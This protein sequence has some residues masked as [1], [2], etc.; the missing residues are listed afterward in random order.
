V[1]RETGGSAAVT[2]PTLTKTNYTEWAILMRIALQGAGLWEAMDTSDAT[3]RQ[4][5]QALGAILRSVSSDMVSALAAG[6]KGKVAWDMLKTMRIGDNR[7]REARH[8][9]L[10][11]E[12]NAMAFKSGES[13]ED[14]SMCMSSLVSELQSLGNSTTELDAVQKTLRVVPK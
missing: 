1:V 2:F 12:F 11:K 6:D 5:R 3:E 4:E 8:Q 7:V 9:K 14:F 13:V 10:R